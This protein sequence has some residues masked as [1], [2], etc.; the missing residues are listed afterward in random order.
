MSKKGKVMVAVMVAVL[1]V[2][3]LAT[4]VMA[5]PEKTSGALTAGMNSPVLTRLAEI[6]GITSEQLTEAFQQAWQDVRGENATANQAAKRLRIREEKA[7]RIKEQLMEKQQARLEKSDEAFQ[8]IVDKGLD[9][10]LINE[11]EALEIRQW[12]SERPVALDK[13][14]PR[15][16]PAARGKQMTAV[17][18]G[19]GAKSERND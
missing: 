13:L 10:G 15:I 9:K 3:G 16:A 17:P 7:E 19:K 8:K 14:V 11:G 2:T 6:L 12:W 4:A 5:Q 18:R 1:L